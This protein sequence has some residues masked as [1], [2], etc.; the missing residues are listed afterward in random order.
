VKDTV[1][2]QPR[3]TD[4]SGQV[5]PDTG[6]YRLQGPAKFKGVAVDRLIG[7]VTVR[8]N[9]TPGAYTVTYTQGAAAEQ[10]TLQVVP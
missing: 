3:V 9:A 10:V 6:A 2:A 1:G 7:T 5:L 4:A 8:P